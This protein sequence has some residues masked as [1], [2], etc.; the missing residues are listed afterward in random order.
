MMTFD[1][2]PA[3]DR[4]SSG[5]QAERATVMGS[6]SAVRLTGPAH[7]PP[8][9]I[10]DAAQSREESRAEPS[11]GSW[12]QVSVAARSVLEPMSWRGEAAWL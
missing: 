6:L 1:P 8:R 11:Q 12:V 5:Q 3:G 9:R 10:A 4:D 7:C 2:G